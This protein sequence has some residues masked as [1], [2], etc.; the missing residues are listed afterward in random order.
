MSSRNNRFN[1]IGL[2]YSIYILSSMERSADF[3]LK[4]HRYF[5]FST[6][7]VVA[8]YSNPPLSFSSSSR[9][10][11]VRLIFTPNGPFQTRSRYAEGPFCATNRKFR[12][13]PSVSVSLRHTTLI[14]G[15]TKGSWSGGQRPRDLFFP[16]SFCLLGICAFIELFRT[17]RTAVWRKLLKWTGWMPSMCSRIYHSTLLLAPCLPW[18]TNPCW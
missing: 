6:A 18:C 12:T 9:L 4:V 10:F 16:A 8:V 14:S 5:L 7:S 17:Y 3:I 2:L 15:P 13:C 11:L 1:I